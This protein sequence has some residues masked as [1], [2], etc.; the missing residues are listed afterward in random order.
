MLEPVKVKTNDPKGG[1]M[2][3]DVAGDERQ[4]DGELRKES[5]LTPPPSRRNAEETFGFGQ[6]Q[7]IEDLRAVSMEWWRSGIR[8]PGLE[9]GV[10][11]GEKIQ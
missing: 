2:T 10:P 8:L 5:D 3:G 9:E 11:G 7:T 6:K 4:G 1:K